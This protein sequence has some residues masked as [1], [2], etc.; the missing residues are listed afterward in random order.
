[1]THRILT[2]LVAVALVPAAA[3]AQTTAKPATPPKPAAAKPKVTLPP[4]VEA[5][6]KAAYPS[7][8]I[9]NVSKEKEGGQEIYEV[10]SVDRGLHRDL[11]YKADG[12]VVDMEEEVAE[13][14]FP[15]SVAAAIKPRYPKA[16]VAK[17]EKLTKGATVTYEIQLKG[18]PG[19]VV[20][21]PDGKWISPKAKS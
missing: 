21:T 16:T 1:M 10:E 5:A 13:A 2:A 8:T 17:R 9:N 15:A 18:G 6:F 19:E 3:L 7:A 14:D 20:L 4:A 11:N 12:T